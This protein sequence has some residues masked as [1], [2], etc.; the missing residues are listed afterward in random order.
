MALFAEDP[1]DGVHDVRFSTAIGADNA[2]QAA[3]A[4]CDCGFFAKRFE[5][6]QLN[7]AQFQQCFLFLA[8]A[9]AL[10]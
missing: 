7:F 3:A 2:G 10:G 8:R 1:G 6:Q 9:W 4:E 5:S